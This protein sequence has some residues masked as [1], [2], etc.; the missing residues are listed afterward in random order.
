[1]I[2]IDKGYNITMTRGDTFARTLSLKR[3]GET[4][5]PNEGDVITFTLAKCYKGSRG[6]E[7]L[8]QKTIDPTT[9]LLLIDAEDTAGLEYGR[10]FYDLQIVYATTGYTETFANKKVLTLTEE[11]G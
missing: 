6:Y 7:A 1:M 10:Y 3:N 5:T 8:I 4:Y 2:E 11:V 9:L